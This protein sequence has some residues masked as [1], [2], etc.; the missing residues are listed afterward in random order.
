MGGFLEQL[1]KLSMNVMVSSMETI[2]ESMETITKT[3]QVR[4]QEP[5]TPDETEDSEGTDEN[6]GKQLAERVHQVVV[7][8]L[9]EEKRPGGLLYGAGV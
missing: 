4:Q 8:T 9:I 1:M 2:T 3:M 6:G 5:E 7:G